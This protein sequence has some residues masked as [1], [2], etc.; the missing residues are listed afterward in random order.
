M[1]YPHQNGNTACVLSFMTQKGGMG[2]TTLTQLASLHL[3]YHG[4]RVLVI[5][6]DSPQH[7]FDIMRR[8][9]LEDLQSNEGLRAK[10]N[11]GGLPLLPLKTASLSNL[12]GHLHTLKHSGQYDYIF[13]DVPGTLAVEGLNEL[14]RE[15]DVVLLPMEM[16]MKSFVS[17][18]QTLDYILSQNPKVKLFAYW[19]R[20]KKAESEA[21]ILNVNQEIKAKCSITVLKKRLSD[22]VSIKRDASTVFPPTQKDVLE[23]MDELADNRIGTVR[24]LA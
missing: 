18:L 16:D 5:D 7:S 13:V 19:N 20:I 3:Y 10:F 6:A 22:L 15:L 8:Q 17:G 4:S 11:E 9:E 2:K 12:R 23:F 1:A 24:I 14:I 21:M